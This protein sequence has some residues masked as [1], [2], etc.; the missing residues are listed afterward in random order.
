M[1]MMHEWRE[2]LHEIVQDVITA[3]GFRDVNPMRIIRRHFDFFADVGV[4]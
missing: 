4:P 3:V 1:R 2:I